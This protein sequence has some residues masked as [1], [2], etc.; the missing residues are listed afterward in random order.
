MARNEGGI[1]VERLTI[2][3]S[4]FA[5]PM[6]GSDA[7]SVLQCVD[8]LADIE[9]ILGDDYDLD[10]L[11]ELIQSDRYGRCVVLPCKVGD[12]VWMIVRRETCHVERWVV[13]QVYK[14]DGGGWYFKLKNNMLSKSRPNEFEVCTRAICRFGKTVFLTREAAEAALKGE[15]NGK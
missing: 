3:K 10:R 8:R 4:D 9:D 12:T 6:R 5:L 14:K 11:R 13:Y 1:S 7:V 15:Q 2:R